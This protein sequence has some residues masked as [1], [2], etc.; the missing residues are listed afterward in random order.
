[1]DME[2]CPKNRESSKAIKF[3]LSADENSRA[4]EFSE[5]RSSV[6]DTLIRH[7]IAVNSSESYIGFY[8]RLH[9]EVLVSR[10]ICSIIW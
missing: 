7:R 8:F 5:L 10:K 1:M 3:H 9:R 6:A 4:R 2:S